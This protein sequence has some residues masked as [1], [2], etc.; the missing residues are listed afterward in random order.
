M[1]ARDDLFDADGSL[2]L[3]RAD[4]VA[5]AHGEYHPLRPLAE[6]FFGYSVARPEV[7]AR[8]LGARPSGGRA[9]AK[10]GGKRR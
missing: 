2:H 7:L 1:Y 4:L 8:R 5:Y 6:G 10:K 3:E 9:P